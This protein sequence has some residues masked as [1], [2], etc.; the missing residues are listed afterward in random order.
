MQP[1]PGLLNHA[2]DTTI[3]VQKVIEEIPGLAPFKDALAT[4]AFLHDFG[5]TIWPD[6]LHFV[7]PLKKH[8]SEII[9]DH[10]RAGA[11]LVRGI[12]PEV[13]PLVIEIITLHH[14]RPGGRGY[15][16]VEPSYPALVVAACEVFAAMTSPRPYRNRPIE[17]EKAIA[18]I[19]QW[20][21]AEITDALKS[22]TTQRL[23]QSRG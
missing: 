18:H 14:A 21:P 15:P 6:E 13:D 17:P 5:K 23:S 22:T 8:E 10:P 1:V 11:N 7:F 3:L 4:G 2:R 16:P 19:E 20:A 9:K 12:W